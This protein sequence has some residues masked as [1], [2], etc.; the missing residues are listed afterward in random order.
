MSMTYQCP[1]YPY[2]DDLLHNRLSKLTEAQQLHYIMLTRL[3][4]LLNM[5][6]KDRH[7]Q[8]EE[9]QL[10][11]FLYDMYKK[12]KPYFPE[13]G[14]LIEDDFI[15][16]A[17]N[18]YRTLEHLVAKPST[19]LCREHCLQKVSAVRHVGGDTMRWLAQRPGRSVLEKISPQ[20]KLMA[21]KT[22]FSTDTKENQEMLYLYGILKNIVRDRLQDVELERVD[23]QLLTSLRKLL[24]LNMKI[25][26]SDLAYVV[27]KKQAVPN[28]K[29]LCDQYYRV[30][31]KAV[32]QIDNIEHKLKADWQNLA[33]RY[34][35]LGFLLILSLLI[36][37]KNVKIKDYSGRLSDK[38]G[39]LALWLQLSAKDG[40]SKKILSRCDIIVINEAPYVLQLVLQ[41]NIVSLLDKK[42]KEYKFQLD[43]NELLEAC[44]RKILAIENL[45]AAEAEK[46]LLQAE[47][48]EFRQAKETQQKCLKTEL[49]TFVQLLEQ[50]KNDKW[51]A[52]SQQQ[53]LDCVR[54]IMCKK[55]QES[56]I[57]ILS[58]AVCCVEEE[59]NK[60]F[61]E[62]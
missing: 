37:D 33:K 28:N 21:S 38:E 41:D 10:L 25:R 26:K 57:A 48:D 16:I 34:A 13:A 31:W 32:N 7:G 62:K 45:L 36:K 14:E 15:T 60:F 5:L 12:L 58:A 22:I 2:T 54:Q 42:T 40:N 6:P 46:Q 30:V 9:K 43:F 51:K 35:Y 61:D 55:Q 20:N 27:P 44:G 18:T 39:A 49:T 52:C 59:N 23:V 17:K 47:Y 50:Y 29:L 8:D 19:K 1:K 4:H 24:Y 11:N 53:I 3:N 56:L